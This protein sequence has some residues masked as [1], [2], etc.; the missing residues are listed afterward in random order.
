MTA[1][2][3]LGLLTFFIGLLFLVYPRALIV[4]SDMF[5]QILSTDSKTLKYRISAGL[6]FLAVGIFFLFM[7]YYFY[8]IFELPG[9]PL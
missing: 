4:L 2:L 8:R 3:L 6:I 5:N 9:L 1:F 7:A